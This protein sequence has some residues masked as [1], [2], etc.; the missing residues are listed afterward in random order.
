MEA[1]NTDYGGLDE[2][3]IILRG[4]ITDRR[5]EPS[6]E[7]INRWP[8]IVSASHS[9]LKYDSKIGRDVT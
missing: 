1:Q 8:K 3:P 7:E 6:K 4:Q 2:E 5:G 9:P